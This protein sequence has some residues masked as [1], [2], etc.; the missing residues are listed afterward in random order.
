MNRSKSLWL[1]ISLT[2]LAATI[3]LA[4]GFVYALKDMLSPASAAAVNPD[5]P[6]PAAAEG[7]ALAGAKEIKIAALGDSLTKGAGDSTG[8]GYVKQT[9]AALQ[10]TASKPVEL[11]NNMALNGL[12]SDELIRLLDTQ[13]GMSYSLKQANLILLTIGG[14]DLFQTAVDEEE[15]GNA[16]GLSPG[17][18]AAKLDDSLNNLKL[19]LDKLHAINPDATLVYVGL[20]NPFY[21]VEQ[22]RS[23]S[24]Q[25]QKWNA[26]AYAMLQQYPNRILVPTFDLFETNIGTYL[27]SDHFHPNHDGYARIAE[28]IVQALS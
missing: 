6:A 16:G 19:L 23:G 17:N 10:Q 13:E 7:G 11:L 14:N 25:V 15:G 28:R 5:L 22:L 21:D 2:A 24:I 1:A 3:V 20:Y 27:S 18:V 8:D 4:G 9:V 26:E 12:R